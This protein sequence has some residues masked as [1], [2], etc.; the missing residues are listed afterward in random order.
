MSE[1]TL[2]LWVTPEQVATIV[3]LFPASG[4]AHLPAALGAVSNVTVSWGPGVSVLNYDEATGR[5]LASPWE[6]VFDTSSQDWYYWN[7]ETSEATWD[8]PPGVPHPGPV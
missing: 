8:R 7:T 4:G 5:R 6:A 1:P 3:S 2:A